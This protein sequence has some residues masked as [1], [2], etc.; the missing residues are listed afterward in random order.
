MAQCCKRCRPSC[1]RKEAGRTATYY[2]CTDAQWDST[3]PSGRQVKSCLLTGL[4]WIGRLLN[5][6]GWA[7]KET[8]FLPACVRSVSRCTGQ[9]SPYS[10]LPSCRPGALPGTARAFR[11]PR[12]TPCDATRSANHINAKCISLGRQSVA[13]PLA[14]LR[15]ITT[16][17]VRLSVRRG[18][19]DPATQCPARQKASHCRAHDASPLACF[20]SLFHVPFTLRSFSY[21]SFNST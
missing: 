10:R 16:A 17:A 7:L 20:R 11:S 4:N 19:G 18:R 2:A 21:T 1:R 14:Q 12:A 9:E 8:I 13:L 5:C 3:A 6:P 15:A